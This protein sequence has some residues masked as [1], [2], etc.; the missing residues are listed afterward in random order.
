MEFRFL[1]HS[2]D[3]AAQVLRTRKRDRLVALAAQDVVMVTSL[4]HHVSSAAIGL[5]DHANQPQLRQQLQRPVDTDH[6]QN[7]SG[8]RQLL[9]DFQGGHRLGMALKHPHY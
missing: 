9:V 3:Q 8:L 7:V 4:S 5:I 2:L 6:S 1:F